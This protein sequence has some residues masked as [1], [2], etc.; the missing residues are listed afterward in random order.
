MA[1]ALLVASSSPSSA[2]NYSLSRYKIAS[3]FIVMIQEEVGDTI[4]R[5]QSSDY[6]GRQQGDKSIHAGRCG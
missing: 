4:D 1:S 5:K 3:T 6:M 2:N